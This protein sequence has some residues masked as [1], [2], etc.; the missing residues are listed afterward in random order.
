MNK[1]GISIVE[2]VVSITL[3]SLV[4]IFLIIML[5]NLKSHDTS[6]K[7]ESSLLVSKSVI[8]QAIQADLMDYKLIGI[9]NCVH[10]ESTYGG[11][12]GLT[13]RFRAVSG[14][15]QGNSLLSGSR[16]GRCIR[17]NFDIAEN[18]ERFGFLVQ[19][20]YYN[21][22]DS[23]CKPIQVVGYMRGS[24][25]VLRKFDKKQPEVFEGTGVVT[26]TINGTHNAITIKLP[27]VSDSGNNYDIKISHAFNL[28]AGGN[29]AYGCASY[30]FTCTQRNT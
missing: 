8:I 25:R 11:H 6:A 17:F 10:D 29:F 14:S 22:P 1:R 19:Y 3:I 5:T 15:N 16:A 13:T 23:G 26:R 30:G 18:S 28:P 9:Q 27:L 2:I 21:C 4:I 7:E 12:G 24:K 20:F